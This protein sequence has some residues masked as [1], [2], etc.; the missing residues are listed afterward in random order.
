MSSHVKFGLVGSTPAAAANDLRYQSSW[1]FDLYGAPKSLSSHIPV[2]TGAGS[3]PAVRRSFSSAVYGRRKPAWENSAVNTTSRLT[4][5]I[6]LSP[7]ARRRTICSR[8]AV[9]VLGSD[10]IRTW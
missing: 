4:T 2:S 1:A 3:M 7:A 6:E 10:S 5:S 8:C 9:A